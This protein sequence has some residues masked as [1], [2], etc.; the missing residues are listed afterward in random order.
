MQKNNNCRLCSDRDETINHIISEYSELDEKGIQD[1]SRQGGKAILWELCKSLKLTILID[2]ICTNQNLPQKMRY[3]SCSYRAIL[4]NLSIKKKG[5][6]RQKQIFLKKGFENA[7]LIRM[8]SY[9]NHFIFKNYIN[10]TIIFRIQGTS[11][12]VM[13][14]SLLLYMFP[15]TSDLLRK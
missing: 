2:G 7:L 11:L 4:V 12:C 14:K 8:F 10:V 6:C 13:L 3:I 5:V 1:L 15:N 9:I